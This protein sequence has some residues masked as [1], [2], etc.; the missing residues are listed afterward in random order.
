MALTAVAV[1]TVIGTLARED[2]TRRLRAELT[3]QADLTISL[4]GGLMLEAIIVE[5]VPVLE[6][7]LQE[8][9]ARKPQILSI[10]VLDPRRRVIAEARSAAVRNEDE[11]V[12]HQRPI[13][14]E[15]E[16]FGYMHVEWSL[17]EGQALIAANV[18]KTLLWTGATVAA[19]SLAFLVLMHLLAMRPL[20]MIHQRMSDAISGLKRPSLFLPWYASRE[21]A[22]L[23]FSVGVLEDTFEERDEREQAL[24]KARTQADIAN[25][26]KSDFL[27]NMSHE[28]RT[29]MNGVIGMA[30][31]MLETDL[32]EDQQMYAS[33]IASSGSAL[34]GIIND[35]LNFSKIE[36]NKIEL[37]I[38]PFNLQSAMEDIVTLL[39]PKALEKSVEVSLRYGPG[40][41]VDFEGDVG[42]IR[43][44]VTNIAGNA[45]KFT[46][47][48]FVCIDVDGVENGSHYDLT[49]T[50]T[51]TG[52]GI[53]DEKIG[54]IFN[55]FEQV[56]NAATRNFEGTGLGLAI[57][58]R[59]MRLMNG[60]VTATSQPGR[61]SVFTIS[62]PLPASSQHS[63]PVP[64]GQPIKSGLR[65]LIVDDL[66]LNRM[67]LKER[68][69]SWGA[70][71]TVAASGAEALEILA[72]SR[73]LGGRFDLII[74]DYMMPG[75]DGLE[76]AEKIRAMPEHRALPLVILSSAEQ[77]LGSS[78]KTELAP[79][80]M[81]LKPVRSE[82]LKNVI[83]RI[84][85]QAPVP[86][87][88]H[89]ALSGPA[90]AEEQV[91]KVLLAEDNLTNQLVVRKM[92]KSYPVDIAVAANGADAVA[93]YQEQRPDII[94]M[95]MMMPEMDGVEATQRI[96]ILESRRK[97]GHCPVIA[98]TANA[99]PA[100]QEKCLA[101]GMDDFLSKPVSKAAL[102][103]AILKWSGQPEAATGT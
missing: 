28:I 2:E 69:S 49:I 7:A 73:A 103:N 45:V 74:Q 46:S 56:D 39:S 101:A 14:W 91:L 15:G 40:L 84:L 3:E 12:F 25:S 42:R 51:D 11:I 79:C 38:A 48:G 43:Q 44:V 27:A 55:A 5:D 70:D 68:L 63:E 19:L 35:I 17:R 6:T 10:Q 61:G 36:A 71:C 53:P 93:A 47:D 58:A 67:I 90:G 87:Q 22:A 54:H 18:R 72:G 37:E 32:D 60:T 21:L 76:L 100:D 13:S 96:R 98:L 82:Q 80:E 34:L 81:V 66:E 31:L 64:A 16:D 57:S 30:E 23:N 78:A 89:A 97:L 92:L 88:M 9:V 1:A 20:Q 77:Q 24:E 75:I 65:I 95:D 41:P 29:P 86:A 62:V 99:L 8:A 26:A 94:L 59:L 83:N 102:W 33:T 85:Q 52:I 4:L 50:V